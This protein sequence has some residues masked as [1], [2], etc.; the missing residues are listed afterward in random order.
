MGA[1]RNG[2][3]SPLTRAPRLKKIIPI[4][5][6]IPSPEIIRLLQAIEALPKKRGSQEPA[7]NQICMTQK[8]ALYSLQSLHHRIKHQER[9]FIKEIMAKFDI[10]DTIEVK[11]QAIL[12]SE[13]IE[14]RIGKISGYVISKNK[15]ILIFDVGGEKPNYLPI[16]LN[17]SSYALKEEKIVV[18]HNDEKTISIRNPEKTLLTIRKIR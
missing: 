8:E 7:L 1:I 16:Y 5:R 13:Q 9:F 11:R 3:V 2:L 12:G 10:E 14:P 18:H 17:P 6:R 4:N 15:A